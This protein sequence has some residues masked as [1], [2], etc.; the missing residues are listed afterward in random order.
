MF[1]KWVIINLG[2]EIECKVWVWCTP[3]TSEN[4]LQNKAFQIIKNNLLTNHV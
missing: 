1:G 2:S 4:E 3:S